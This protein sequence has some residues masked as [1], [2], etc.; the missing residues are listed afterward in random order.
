MYNFR[1]KVKNMQMVYFTKT[2]FK[3]LILLK[4]FDINLYNKAFGSI[5]FYS[6]KTSFLERDD[7]ILMSVFN[8]T[9]LNLI[10][11]SHLEKGTSLRHMLA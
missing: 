2:S 6:N 11:Q 8:Q 9:G 7:D 1:I 4:L 3:L 10:S 5:L